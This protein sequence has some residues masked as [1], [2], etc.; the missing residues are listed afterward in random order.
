MFDK[1]EEY[2]KNN[3]NTPKKRIILQLYGHGYHHTHKYSHHSTTSIHHTMV[4]PLIAT[5]DS[6]TNNYYEW[7][8]QEQTW[9]KILNQSPE[10]PQEWSKGQYDG[11]IRKL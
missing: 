5:T 1:Y 4:T 8:E 7:N 10:P 2:F 9:E 11:E 3:A 6:K